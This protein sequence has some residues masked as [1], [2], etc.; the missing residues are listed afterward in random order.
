[1][2]A[3]TR[4]VRPV[5]AGIPLSPTN[6]E[7]IVPEHSVKAVPC[8]P[9]PHVALR[10]KAYS[11]KPS[12]TLDPAQPAAE[13]A[14]IIHRSLLETLLINEPGVRQNA[15][16]EFLH[17]LRVSVRRARSA[18]AQLEGVFPADVTAHLK[19][20]LKW[21]QTVTGPMR[22]LD[23]YRLNMDEY[24]HDLPEAIRKDLDPLETYLSNH[25]R[26]EHE[27]LVAALDSKR[28]NA[29]LRDW[30]L[31]DE[32]VP[33]SD[34]EW[35]NAR[36]PILGFAAERTWQAYRRVRRKGDAITDESPDEALH[37][38]R[39]DCKKLRYL[40][41]FFTLLFGP[42]RTA[43]V[44]E[45]LKLL[46]DNLGTFHDLSVQ[47]EKLASF[48]HHMVEEQQVGA[49]ALLA[50]GR[51]VERLGARQTAER[52]RFQRSYAAFAG[53]RTRERFR[54]LTRARA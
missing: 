29:L 24:R 15:D 45:R 22:D 9:A 8:S 21:L 20:E 17:D 13:A 39:I 47:Q 31:L 7:L 37:A 12:L 51:L 38:L 49:D 26:I 16:P 4:P 41:E 19:T 14:R 42:T 2:Q 48:S 54:K 18:L 3:A 32:G 36:R 44:I 1:L 53:K 33:A 5:R 23:V 11:S 52:T 6:E 34:E 35:P 30:R 40:L 43:R 50:M 27:R 46:Q 28:F 10:P 25:H